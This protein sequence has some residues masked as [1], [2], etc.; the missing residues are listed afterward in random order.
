MSTAIFG[1]DNMP[2]PP[3]ELDHEYIYRQR[4][5]GRKWTLIAADLGV[6]VNTL[7]NWRKR[8]DS[9]DE[10]RQGLDDVR[11][12]SPWRN[13]LRLFITLLMTDNNKAR[14]S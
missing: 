1:A 11:M 3:I 5:N 12:M 13:S 6:H 2:H 9:P 4:Q 8:V 10:I 14:P 7:D